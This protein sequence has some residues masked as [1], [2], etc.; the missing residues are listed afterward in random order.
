MNN[1]TIQQ[2]LNDDEL[3]RLGKFLDG[4]GAPAMNLEALDGYFVALIC[5]PDLVLPS[6]YLPAIWGED[7]CFDDHSQASD[8]LDLLMRHWNAISL[9]LLRSLKQPDVYMPVLIT[10]DEG[11]AHGNDWARGFL[12]CVE[13]Y[14]ASWRE[15]VLSEEHGGPLIPIMLLAHEHDPDPS[16]RP[17][18]VPPDK[19]EEIL[20]MM[21]A[22]LTRIY[23]Y[24]EPHRRSRATAS[25]PA[26]LRREGRKIGRNEPCPCGSGLKYKRC[27]GSN[28]T[29]IH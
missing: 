5:G 29:T 21:I 19:R 17:K 24:F 15:L 25:R 18:P 3:N 11:V 20:S 7:F 16:M 23:R 14:P 12:R 2:P 28:A 4:I 1:A 27:C 8:I 10:D 26:P 22:G 6:E 9:D 13:E